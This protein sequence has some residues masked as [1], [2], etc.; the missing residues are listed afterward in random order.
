MAEG[1]VAGI[2]LSETGATRTAEARDRQE[3]VTVS[4]GVNSCHW[5]ASPGGL[6]SSVLHLVFPDFAVLCIHYIN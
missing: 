1:D 2:L 6:L 3:A 5:G 4:E